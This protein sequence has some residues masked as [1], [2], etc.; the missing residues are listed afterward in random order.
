MECLFTIYYVIQFQQHLEDQTK[1]YGIVGMIVTSL[2]HIIY[3]TED[4]DSDTVW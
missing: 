2:A 3:V 1:S 4:A